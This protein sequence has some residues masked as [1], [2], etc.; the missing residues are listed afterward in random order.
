MTK[1]THL[2]LVGLLALSAGPLASKQAAAAAVVAGQTVQKETLG[3]VLRRLAR[4]ARFNNPHVNGVMAAPPTITATGPTVTPGLTREYRVIGPPAASGVFREFGGVPSVYASV[5]HRFPVASANVS[6]SGGNVDDGKSANAWQV[7]TMA[8]AS[9]VAFRLLGSTLP[10]RFLVQSD[11]TGGRL[12]YVDT[13]GT[14]TSGPS[15]TQYITLDFGIRALRKIIIEGELAQGFDGAYVGPTETLSPTDGA[16]VLRAVWLTDSYGHSVVGGRTNDNFANVASRALGF[17]DIRVSAV[18]GAGWLN[19]A[20]GTSYTVGQRI[21]LDLV[22]QAPDVAFI[23]AG[24]NDGTAGLTAE[25]TTRIRQ[26]RAA[27]PATPLLVLGT[28]PGQTGPDASKTAV[29]AAVAAGVSAAADPLT[30]FVPVISDPAGSW[31]TGTGRVG[32]TAGVGNSDLYT[33]ADTVHP[34]TSGH[35]YLGLRAAD[36]IMAKLPLL[37]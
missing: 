19:T 18:G 15:G 6:G 23:A 27:M 33:S 32:A 10:F 24:A 34:P 4:Q 1:L 28:W 12:Q 36:A 20:G 9:K 37:D 25:V 13:T 8:D 29:E 14:V 3:A 35:L 26:F 22:P 5:F 16:D 7:E 2:V 30:I 11:A 17:R 31:V 21:A